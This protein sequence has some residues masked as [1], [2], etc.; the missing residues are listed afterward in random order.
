MQEAK[1]DYN[2]VWIVT[3][4]VFKYFI[5]EGAR[6]RVE[7]KIQSGVTY[8]YFVRSPVDS[9]KVTDLE[10]LKK[11]AAEVPKRLAVQSFGEEEFNTQSATD[12]IIMNPSPNR[13]H[14]MRVFL[15]LPVGQADEEYW[16]KVEDEAAQH[17]VGRFSKMWD[18]RS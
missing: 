17:F 6:E 16:I 8:R 12:Y 1:P 11:R 5:N 3:P 9:D 14:P 15:K 18:R 7:M 13:E 2:A 4:D 10:N